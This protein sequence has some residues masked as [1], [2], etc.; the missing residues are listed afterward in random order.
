MPSIDTFVAALKGAKLL[1][2]RASANKKLCS[3]PK[4]VTVK[5]DDRLSRSF[6]KKYEQK[7]ATRDSK[8]IN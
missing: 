7:S 2:L 5:Q 3:S 4:Q 8:H 6:D 1:D